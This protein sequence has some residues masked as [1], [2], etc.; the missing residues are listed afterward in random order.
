MRRIVRHLMLVF[1]LLAVLYSA[2]AAAAA[3]FPL[4][5][6]DIWVMAGDSITAQHLHSNYFEAFCFARYPKMKFA[7]RN[8]GVGGHTIPSTLARFDYDIAAWKP[9]IVS[10]ELG[11]NDK[12]GTTT[13]KF[14]ANMGTM[15]ERIRSIKAQPVIFAA[16]PVNNGETMKSLNGNKRLDEY[17]VALKEFCAKE[18]IPYADQFHD[19]VDIWGK[20]KPRETVANSLGALKSAA[21]DES[22]VGVEH[23]R[24]FLAAQDKTPMKPVSMQGD[25]VHPGPPGQ[26]MMAAALL[27]DLGAQGFVSSA[28][29]DAA[30][31]VADSK[32]CTIDAVKAA[33][34]KL[35]FD[36]LDECVAFP[37][38]EEARAVLPLYPTILELSQYTLKVT[39]LKAGNYALKINGIPTATLSAKE[40]EAG[41][42]LTA[43]GPSPQSKEVNPV[44][45]Q[46][47]AIL[48]A[49]SA[50]EGIVGS[51]RGLSQKA[52]A[53]DAPAELKDQLAALTKKV[54]EADVK[55]REAAKPQKLHFEIVPTP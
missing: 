25:A 42:N 54:E 53:K 32:G 21:Q 34:G 45:A 14:I 50:K 46:G 22:L 55:I 24:A 16:S 2:P 26:L 20:N 38:P 48:A 30:G 35:A 44:A 36:R 8:S 51:W 7:F 33:D 43:F 27:K 47:K 28:T 1:G 18:R 40:L 6:G 37:I 29:V 19:L 49:V 15:V 12:G 4:K 52:H 13:D 17:A 23:L 41:V 5:E 3:D 9:A 31:K 10:V 11:M 39:G